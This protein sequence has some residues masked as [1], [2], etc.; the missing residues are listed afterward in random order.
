MSRSVGV[1]LELRLKG[2]AGKQLPA[3]WRATEQEIQ[4]TRDQAKALERTELK[5]IDDAGK[6]KTTWSQVGQQV[7][8]TERKLSDLSRIEATLNRQ[9]EMFERYMSQ[10]ARDAGA[11]NRAVQSLSFS[12]ANQGLSQ[13]SRLAS[14]ATKDMTGLQ[15]LAAGIGT[16]VAAGAGA[17]MVLQRPVRDTIQYE[18]ELAELSNTAYEKDDRKRGQDW[19]RNTIKKTAMTYGQT[20]DSVFDGL[21]ALIASGN[22]K[23]KTTAETEANLK[24]A[25]E[26]VAMGAQA[27]GGS[28]FDF[29]QLAKQARLKGLDEKQFMGL[30]IQ[31]GKEG[32][33]EAKDLARYLPD[34]FGSVAN[35]PANKLRQAAQLM[36]L[37]EVAMTTAGASSDAATNVKNLLSKMNVKTTKDTLQKDYG[38]N[39]DAEYLKGAAQG[40]TQFDV[41]GEALTKAMTS[42]P[43]YQK[44]LR[45]MS[46]AKNSD[47][48]MAI[49]QSQQGILERS[50]LS[51]VL[52][53]MQAGAAGVAMVAQKAEMER[54]A[55]AAIQKGQQ[56]MAEDAQTMR[57]TAYYGLNK[58]KVAAKDAEF[59]S[60][61]GLSATIGEAS[62]KLADYA[63]KYP[64]L[65]KAV[66]GTTITMTALAASGGAAAA[67]QLLLARNAGAAGSL[68]SL[69]GT[70]TG[71]AGRLAKLG[72]VGGA[73]GLGY[74]AGEALMDGQS[75]ETKDAIGG[76]VASV[77]AALGNQTAQD[78]LDWQLNQQPMLNGAPQVK[79][80]LSVTIDGQQIAA[81]LQD[82]QDRMALRGPLMNLPPYRPK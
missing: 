18:K 24:R 15:K 41:F 39:L 74:M 19:L 43:A 1:N 61:R 31:S 27:S 16:G 75:N 71:L 20:T 48:R 64:D 45:M 68:A 35:D 80:E 44:V 6:L 36:A 72:L 10:S 77:L 56:S 66:A 8:S 7:G 59:E 22:Y 12:Q 52:P 57:E 42:D 9:A 47:E 78:A 28:V 81:V 49:L 69:S 3:L 17:A 60:M 55:Q 33:F 23:G 40:K 70:A 13:F 62:S 38:I 5:L 29:V 51:V 58:G 2:D 82:R 25:L 54:I 53:D 67:A 26:A 73:F 4:R 76:T 32:S 34:H 37:N 63:D 50:A 46:S 30:A 21:A 11:L 79:N 65:A 14:Q